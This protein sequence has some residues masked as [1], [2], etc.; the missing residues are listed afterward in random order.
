MRTTCTAL[1]AALLLA[2]AA[3][4]GG[5][6]DS[7]AET[8]FRAE[9]NAICAD[10]RPKLELLAPPAEDVDEWAAIAADLGD[11]LEASV[12]ELRLLEAP[13]DLSGDYEDWVDLRAELLTTVREL[14]DAGGLHD[15]AGV[16]A[17]LLQADE[18]M[19]EADA[20]AEELELEDCSPTGIETGL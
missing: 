13:G 2:V 7:E 1:L 16:D 5:D 18:T 4:C 8:A 19:T 15:Q 9:V 14:Q 20:L 10:Y 6:D 11:L 12:N 3:A 17:A